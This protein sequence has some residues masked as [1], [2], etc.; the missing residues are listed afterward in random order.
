[1]AKSFDEIITGIVDTIKNT[2]GN[3]DTRVGTILRD[4]ILSPISFEFS[5]TYSNI[6]EVSNNQGINT[7]AKQSDAALENLAANYGLSRFVGSPATGS[8]RFLRYSQPTSTTEIPVNTKVYTELSDVR[9]SFSTTS[10]VYLTPTALQDEETGAYYVD[11]PIV[12]DQVGA[13]GNVSAGGI[14]YVDLTGIDGVYNPEDTSSGKDVQTNEELVSTIVATARG[15]IGTRT[16]YDALVRSNFGVSDVE[17]ISGRDADAVRSQYGGSIDIIVLDEN[18]TA[19]TESFVFVDALTTTELVPS[20]KPL[21]NVVQIMGKNDLDEDVNLV[22]GTDY[23]IF[24]DTYSVNRRSI[25]ETS[26]IVLHIS[27]FTPLAGSILT[28]QYTYNANVGNIQSFLEQEE[29]KVL[30]S[31]VMVKL[32]IEVLANVAASITTFPGYSKDSVKQD[33]EAALV[34]HFN[35]FLLDDDV[36][37]SDVIATIANVSGVDSVDVG[38]FVLSRTSNPGVPLAEISASKQQ[39]IRLN[40]V[41]GLNITVA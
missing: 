33:V 30:G 37:D 23:E 27:S 13:V 26:K 6:E 16:G 32:G 2:I 18:E 20:I 3:V 14:S 22:P 40:D 7:A 35:A 24:Y 36:Q 1:M 25:Y 29:N 34:N 17:I 15:N 8:V 5:N 28:V 39:F 31:D 12:C 21:V 19:A 41:D 9:I 4:A 38:S 11:C 10:L